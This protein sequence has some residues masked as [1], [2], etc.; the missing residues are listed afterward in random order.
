M[1]SELGS[2]LKLEV[3]IIV[4]IGARELPVEAVLALAPGS[5]IELPKG[6]EEDLEIK[7]NNKPIGLGQAVKVG[8]NFGVRVKFIGDVKA[9]I[10]ALADKPK[11]EDDTDADAEAL[12]AALLAGQV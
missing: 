8:E 5:I 2:I 11:E 6:V 9:R 3:P 4:E 12:A 1:P 10:L 7:V